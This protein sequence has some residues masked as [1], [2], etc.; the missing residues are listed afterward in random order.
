MEQYLAI[1]DI[2]LIGVETQQEFIDIIEETE[3]PEVASCFYRGAGM[4]WSNICVCLFACLSVR[5]SVCMSKSVCLSLSLSVSLCLS[6][7][8]SVCLCLSF[9]LSIP[10]TLLSFIFF[11]GVYFEDLDSDNIKYSIRLRQDPAPEQSWNTGER[12]QNAQPRGARVSPK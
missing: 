1:S 10:N 6:L 12:S 2:P 8:L 7:S 9:S 4:S 3:S 5:L 11:K